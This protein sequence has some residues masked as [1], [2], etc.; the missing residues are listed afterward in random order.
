MALEMSFA[1]P[2][3]PI[4]EKRKLNSKSGKLCVFG[5]NSE[6]LALQEAS[7]AQLRRFLCVKQTG[8]PLML[9]VCSW[10]CSDGD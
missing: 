1:V 9:V 6:E 7:M 4:W 2:T 5:T 10:S 3:S 8:N